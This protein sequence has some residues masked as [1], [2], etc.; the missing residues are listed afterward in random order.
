[1]GTII[2]VVSPLFVPHLTSPIC[3]RIRIILGV[4]IG[5]AGCVL[6]PI[7]MSVALNKQTIR[8]I[9]IFRCGKRTLQP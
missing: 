6:V 5:S 1:M 3:V 9:A 4:E 2:S 8:N 7:T